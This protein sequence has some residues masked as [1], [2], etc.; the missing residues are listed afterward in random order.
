MNKYLLKKLGVMM[1]VSLVLG[2]ILAGCSQ[3]SSNSDS[4]SASMIN[5]I[6]SLP[7]E[8]SV[9]DSTNAD[10]DRLDEK[11]LFN[12]YSIVNG[13][14]L[15]AILY[16]TETNRRLVSEIQ[17]NPWLQLSC[18]DVDGTYKY[19]DLPRNYPTNTE[20]IQSVKAGEILMDGSDRI[21][22]YYQDAELNGE[23]TKIG[24]FEDAARAAEAIGI[25]DIQLG[26]Y[27]APRKN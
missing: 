10:S 23:Y 24:Y 20:T 4:N 21:L 11:E 26:V 25:E 22:L 13:Q 14:E 3:S 7:S 18:Y 27:M 1:I 19:Y 12:L 17:R 15:K 8:E 16:N 6:P 2:S 5:E 9:D